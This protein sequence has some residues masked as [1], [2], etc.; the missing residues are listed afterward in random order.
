M[1]SKS[2]IAPSSLQGICTDDRGFETT[3]IEPWT[4]LL[5]TGRLDFAVFGIFGRKASGTS[6]DGAPC[7]PRREFRSEW[8]LISGPLFL[9][10]TLKFPGNFPSEKGNLILLCGTPW[11]R[12]PP[13]PPLPHPGYTPSLVMNR[14]S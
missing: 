5:G 1:R 9:L 14:M 6:T 13:N 10:K 2:G 3:G 12:P 11:P 4:Y 8:V 7:W